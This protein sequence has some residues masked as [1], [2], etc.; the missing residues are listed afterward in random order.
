MRRRAV[1]HAPSVPVEQEDRG[2]G[3]RKL[4]LDRQHDLLEHLAERGP[5]DELDQNRLLP[6]R[7]PLAATHGTSVLL[8][9]RVRSGAENDDRPPRRAAGAESD[10]QL[11]L[12]SRCYMR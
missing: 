4:V 12:R 2:A 10:P 1:Q 7:Q 11:R 3:V 9:G 6:P 5:A 8:A